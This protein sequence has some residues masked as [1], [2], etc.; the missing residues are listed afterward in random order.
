MKKL[1]LIFLFIIPVASS[2]SDEKEIV[3]DYDEGCLRESIQIYD[4]SIAVHGDRERA[5]EL[6]SWYYNDCINDFPED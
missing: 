4:S 5:V 3:F 2:A 6:A 1:A